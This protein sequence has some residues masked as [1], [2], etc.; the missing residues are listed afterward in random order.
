MR[1][2][3][4]LSEMYAEKVGD[5]GGKLAVFV[6]TVLIVST[7]LSHLVADLINPVSH[8]QGE[9]AYS[10]IR[11]P[12]DLIVEDQIATGKQRELAEASIPHVFSLNDT[13]IKELPHQLEGMFAVLQELSPKNNHSAS[14]E[15]SATVRQKKGFDQPLN[16]NLSS[17]EW[18]IV[19]NKELRAPLE[20]A[21]LQS[22][23]PLL[24]RGIIANKNQLKK[25]FKKGGKVVLV[26]KSSGQERSL[27]SDIAL[28]SVKEAIEAVKAK[29]SRGEQVHGST[30]GT[31]VEKI[32]LLELKPNVTYNWEETQAR[33]KNAQ[34]EVEPVYYRIKRNEVIVRAG[35]VISPN[36]EWKLKKLQEEL[37][38]RDILSSWLS[39][40]ILSALVLLSVHS[41]TVKLVTTTNFTARDLLIGSS[42]L[43]GSF[44]LIKMCSIIADSL[45]SSS[46]YFDPG[47]FILATPLAAGGILLQTTIGSA[48]V[49]MYI[50][51]FALLSGI[52]LANSWI[53]MVLIVVGNI[54]GAV[55]V[56]RCS[57]RSAF[58]YAAVKISA[59]NVLTVLC[60]LFLYPELSGV[61][62]ANRVV[63]AIVGGLASG[64]LGA[65]LA[66]VAEFFGGYATDIKL[67][68]LASLDQ[69]LL[70]DFS[71]Q[72]PG[73]WNHCVVLGQI[74]EAAAEAVGAN[75]LLARV[76][77]YYHDIG[78]T[79]KPAYFI[80]NQIKDNRHDRLTPSMSALIVKSHVKE[81]I[82]LATKYR[83]PR[84]VIDLIPQ[85]HGTSLIR[86]FY[87]KALGE[88]QEGEVV[89]ENQYRY[90]GPK[91]QTK[92]A[93]ILML[94]D[95][96]EAASRT[97]ADPSPTKI[98]GLVQKIINN[99]FASGELDESE[100]TLNDLHV[101]ARCF[102]RVLN[103][104]YHRRVE[105]SDPAEKTR[106][107]KP[108]KSGK[109]G[110]TITMTMEKIKPVLDS[111]TRGANGNRT[112]SEAGSSHPVKENSSKKPDPVVSKETLKRLG[113]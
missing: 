43:I 62:A 22:I 82:E 28:L 56:H 25:I 100:L 9:V 39:Y 15:Q 32:T 42:T 87:D 70:R 80:E 89:D 95:S 67:L 112:I 98:K 88:A 17:D 111:E 18:D 96:V 5:Q 81:G 36:Q 60:F 30:F 34:Q 33:I 79:A 74:S 59:V 64:I 50:M 14:S 66:P 2:W 45:S 103:G 53:M 69:P 21:I 44:L 93:A 26:E 47:T 46:F 11:A 94:G 105:Y 99:I 12:R 51:S 102:T 77:A 85:H 1:L 73:T 113:I 109:T 104:I 92:E 57:R 20:E 13:L 106:E 76:G 23:S 107:G 29:L 65:G 48:G 4:K 110:S 101:I 24:Q 6:F 40:V 91:P 7:S 68:E 75:P 90:D 52:F 41:F 38:G 63:W 35:D 58:L 72:A 27:D 49:F 55:S 31:L 61:E 78:K 54:V 108:P 83:L 16:I 10:T 8:S 97:L 84:V 3:N 71:V 19:N 86:Y 37:G